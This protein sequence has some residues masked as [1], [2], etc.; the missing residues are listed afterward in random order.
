M[1]LAARLGGWLRQSRSCYL[2]V[3]WGGGDGWR[4]L[5]VVVEVVG[6]V[7]LVLGQR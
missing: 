5:L 1:R 3:A 6:W 2:F 7:G 4:G